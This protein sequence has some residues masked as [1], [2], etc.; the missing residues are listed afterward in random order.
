MITVPVILFAGI[1]WGILIFAISI[2]IDSPMMSIAK[3]PEPLPENKVENQRETKDD[4]TRPLTRKERQQLKTLL[5]QL[6]AKIEKEIR[7]QSKQQLKIARLKITTWLEK[8]EN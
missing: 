7:S 5:A 8:E 3:E 6:D 2:I 4:E 1:G